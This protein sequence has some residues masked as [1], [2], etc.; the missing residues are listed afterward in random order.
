MKRKHLIISSLI[1][2]SVLV[3]LYFFNMLNIIDN[4]V[5]KIIISIKNDNITSFMK[6]TTL[7]AVMWSTGWRAR[8]IPYRPESCC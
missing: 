7:S 5:Y 3:I 8:A 4:S 1:I 6:F 2:F